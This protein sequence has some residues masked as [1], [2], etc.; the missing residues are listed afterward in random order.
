MRPIEIIKVVNSFL[1]FTCSAF[2]IGFFFYSFVGTES[3]YK[4]KDIIDFYNLFAFL[5][6]LVLLIIVFKYGNLL[7]ERTFDFLENEKIE[8]LKS[9]NYIGLLLLSV[10]NILLFNPIFSFSEY[11]DK[12]GDNLNVAYLAMSCSLFLGAVLLYTSRQQI[13]KLHE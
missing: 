12:G 6:N 11:F 3:Y 7:S 4:Y 8:G 13:K 1:S 10:F 5:I 9:G 2:I